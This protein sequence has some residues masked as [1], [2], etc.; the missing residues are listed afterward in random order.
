MARVP[1]YWKVAIQDADELRIWTAPGLVPIDELH[2]T[3]LYLGGKTAAEAAEANDLSP[4]DCQQMF[5]ALQLLNGSEVTLHVTEVLKHTDM[6]VAKVELPNNVACA[7]TLPHLTLCRSPAVAPK[8]AQSLVGCPQS[9]EICKL[10]MPLTL[11]GIVCLE[12]GLAARPVVNDI[13]DPSSF[14]GR[15]LRVETN[16][17]PTRQ[18]EPT[19]HATFLHGTE[20]EIQAWA[21][22]LAASVKT[23]SAGPASLKLK[24]RVQAPGKPG[25]LYLKWGAT[26]SDLAAKEI[27]AVLEARFQEFS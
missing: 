19:G 17:R 3:L 4:E 8:L 14:V 25:H 22:Q 10:P 26:A 5:D 24:A 18:T 7:S 15:F 9:C 2:V 23:Q 27:G 16:P 21:A 13:A 1:L 11:R 12:T 6:I 20:E